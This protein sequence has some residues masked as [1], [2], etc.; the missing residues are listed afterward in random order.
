MISCCWTGSRSRTTTGTSSRLAKRAAAR[1]LW[2]ATTTPA[3]VTSSGWR[4]PC[5]RM[6]SANSSRPVSSTS[7]LGLSGLARSLAMGQLGL[8]TGC[9]VVIRSGP[10]YDRRCECQAGLGIARGTG[11]GPTL[12]ISSD[13]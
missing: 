4:T 10:A 3:G 8:E 11:A 6:D 9:H 1:R 7:P 5:A 12:A 13:S 2:P